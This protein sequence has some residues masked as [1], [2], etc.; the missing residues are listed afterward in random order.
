MPTDRQT[1]KHDESGGVF[2]WLLV[3]KDPETATV[4]GGGGD[5]GRL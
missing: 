3:S 2:V 4:V 5:N 1:V